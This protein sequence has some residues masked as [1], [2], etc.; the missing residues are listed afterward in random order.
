MSYFQLYEA[1]KVKYKQLKPGSI[2]RHKGVPEV[3]VKIISTNWEDNVS[4]VR[5][6]H[7]YLPIDFCNS[8]ILG[9]YEL[10]R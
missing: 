8:Y 1:N 7:H 9:E 2:W 4:L 6:G 3:K 10:V 5:S